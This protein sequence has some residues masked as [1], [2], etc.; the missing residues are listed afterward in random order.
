[1]HLLKKILVP[2]DLSVSSFAGVEYACS[3]TKQYDAEI[4]LVYVIESFSSK[5][6]PY[7]DEF[8]ET[9]F[10]DKD[11]ESLRRLEDVSRKFF[12]ETKKV[13]CAVL[14]GDPVE[15]IVRYARVQDCHLIV[16]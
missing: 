12:P 8:S 1:M 11:S 10:R 5:Q 9:V 3:L 14:R 15:E 7:I 2:T 4:H 6:T 13:T 16:M